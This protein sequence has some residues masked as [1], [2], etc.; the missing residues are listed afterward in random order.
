MQL[1]NLISALAIAIVLPVAFAQCPDKPGFVVK[2]NTN[3]IKGSQTKESQTQ[4]ANAEQICKLDANCLAFN[5]YGYYILKAADTDATLAAAGIKLQPYDD[6][7]TYIKAN[8]LP[9]TCPTKAGFVT[10]ENTNWI[11]GPKTKE[12]QTA[13]ENAEKICNLDANCLAFNSYGYHILKQADSAATIAAA[14][15]KFTPYDGMCTYIKATA[16]S[17]CPDKP[18]FVTR[19]NTNWVAS[20][21][22]K[23]SQ[24]AP[25]SAEKICNLDA[26]CL[27]FNN[28][29]YYILKSSDVALSIAAAGVSF[30]PYDKMCTYVKPAALSAQAPIAAQSQQAKSFV[31]RNA[32]SRQCFA[33]NDNVR[34]PLVGLPRLLASTCLASD[35]SQ[36]FKVVS[37]GKL[38]SIVDAQGRCLT[39]YSGILITSAGFMKCANNRD[40][41]LW[42]LN[43]VTPNGKGPYLI[44]SKETGA[45]IAILRGA[46]T[47]NDCNSRDTSMLFESAFV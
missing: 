10:K 9:L 35:K 4:P 27:A 36:G 19:E 25:D 15:I 33:V 31:F 13:P 22:T 43:S 7:C 21:K 1:L 18:G 24:T 44:Q 5:N 14:G 16:L 12:S 37:V 20:A 6:M 46:V 41:Q 30:T 38:Y 39:S 45:C 26:N 29:G 23:E 47:L 17:S 28:F 34:L 40:D 3:W 11:A 8:A 2:A 32:A 42:A